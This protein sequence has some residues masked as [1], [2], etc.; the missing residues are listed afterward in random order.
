M[1]SSGE[2][3]WLKGKWEASEALSEWIGLS[4]GCLLMSL[5]AFF[6]V[7][8][9][10]LCTSTAIHLLYCHVS[11]SMKNDFYT[12]Y[13]L[14]ANSIAYILLSPSFTAFRGIVFVLWWPL[15]TCT[16]QKYTYF[17]CKNW[18]TAYE[19][20]QTLH[21]CYNL[22]C[23]LIE[24]KILYL[25]MPPKS[26]RVPSA[27]CVCVARVR[28]CVGSLFNVTGSLFVLCLCSEGAASPGSIS[29][30]DP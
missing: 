5:K 23:V 17:P 4:L 30:S 21:N 28:A 8:L 6:A 16:K 27:V 10:S 7:A 2:S 22:T 24:D 3:V 9:P 25:C 1:C 19:Y 29:H 14:P 20:I 18:N 13:S 12:G 15:S 11:S 26:V